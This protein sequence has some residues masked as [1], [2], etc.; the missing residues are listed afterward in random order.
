[1]K[2]IQPKRRVSG[3]YPHLGP[4]RN[5]AR[6]VGR[7]FHRGSR[8]RGG[9]DN[10]AQSGQRHAGVVL[11]ARLRDALVL[12]QRLHGRGRDGPAAAGGTGPQPLLQKLMQSQL[13]RRTAPRL[14]FSFAIDANL[15]SQTISHQ[16]LSGRWEMATFK[17]SCSDGREQRLVT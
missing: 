1:M 16:E 13:R 10:V 6:E 2:Q 4:F 17:V 5:G 3:R 11:E 15:K 8:D 9:R 7:I 12:L 14:H